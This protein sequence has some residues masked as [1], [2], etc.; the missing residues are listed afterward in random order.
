MIWKLVSLRFVRRPGEIELH[1]NPD[2]LNPFKLIW[3]VQS[4]LKKYFASP[5]GQIRTTTPAIPSH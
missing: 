5:V 4:P 3:A 2:F 1:A